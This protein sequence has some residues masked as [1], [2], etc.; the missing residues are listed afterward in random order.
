MKLPAIIICFALLACAGSASADGYGAS[1]RLPHR[2]FGIGNSHRA[3]YF[4][5]SGWRPGKGVRTFLH[6]VGA[7]IHSRREN[8][9][10]RWGR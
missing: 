3:A 8:R 7:R 6:N 4:D 1:G 10:A 5:G 2:Y 9:Q